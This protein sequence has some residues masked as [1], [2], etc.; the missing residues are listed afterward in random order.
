M[1]VWLLTPLIGGAVLYAAWAASAW[2]RYGRHGPPAAGEEDELLDR[3]MPEYDVVERHC[4]SVSAPAAVTFAAACE[5]GLED[6]PVSRTIFRARE[7]LLGARP[8]GAPLPS[9][10][11]AKTKALGWGVLAEIPGREIVMGA[12]TQPWLADVVFRPLPPEEFR[13]F[14]DPDYVK[15]AW[16]LRADPAPGGC[17][18][19]RTETRVLAG[20]AE[21]RSKFRRYWAWLSPGIVLIRMSMLGPL[22]REG[23]RRAR[24]ATQQV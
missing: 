20:G 8:D 2:L 1:T 9:G 17:S 23:E 3:F 16:T 19:F 22:K 7:T 6:S 10:I 15:I 12:V 21:A 11:L 4:T 14:Q 18:I 13:G 5:T 24:A